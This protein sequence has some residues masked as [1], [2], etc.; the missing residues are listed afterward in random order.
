VSTPWDART[1]DRSSE[2]QQEWASEVLARLIAIEPNATVL[3]VGCGTG[4]VTEALLALVPH[5]RVLAFDASKAMVEMARQRLGD[6]A[7]VWCQDVLEL[8]LEAPVDVIVSTA[9]LHWVSDHDRLWERLAA[10]LRPGGTLEIQCGGEGNIK[11]VREVIE[12]VAAEL[13]PELVGWSPWVFAGT[14][15]TERRLQ[16]AGFTATRCWLQERP[17]YPPDVAAFVP[18]SILAAHLDRLPAARGRAF[19]DAVVA[20]VNLPLDYV[21]L[22]VSAIRGT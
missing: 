7:E 22:N 14:R 9:A 19:A 11:G 13:A 6:R 3:D 12:S 17:T 20:N 10:A 2:P 16:L 21:R 5:G 18:T 4:R 15:E 8:D 1:Y